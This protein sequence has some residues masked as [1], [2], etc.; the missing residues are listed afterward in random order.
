MALHFTLISS[1]K[2]EAG[3][4]LYGIRHYASALQ[5][6]YT[7][8]ITDYISNILQYFKFKLNTTCLAQLVTKLSGVL[9]ESTHTDVMIK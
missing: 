6:I 1:R 5:Q 7:I 3:P 2:K 9:Y 8:V 4:W